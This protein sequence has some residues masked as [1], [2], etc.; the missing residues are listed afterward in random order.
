MGLILLS[1]EYLDITN[2]EAQWA[3]DDLLFIF[4]AEVKYHSHMH[5]L[6]NN[7]I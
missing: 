5:H 2:D 7:L 6:L 4:V 1:D 3:L